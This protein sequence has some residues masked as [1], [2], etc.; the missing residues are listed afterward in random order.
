[1]ARVIHYRLHGLPQHRAG[2]VH[3]QFDG[4]VAERSWRSSPPWLATDYSAGLFEMEY[5]RHLR[6]AE[7][8]DVTAGGFLKLAGDETDALVMALFLRDLSAEYGVRTVLRD[9]GNPLAKLRYLEFRSGRLPSGR[10]LEETLAKRPVIKKVSGH[11][12]MFYPPTYRVHSQSPP[13]P[14]RWGYALFGIR[15]FAPSLL[16][17]EREALKILNGLR[18][19]G[20]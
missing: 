12:I 2:R 4:L 20:R 1:M 17:A 5:L 8:A 7:G 18:H 13:G 16:E 9:D 10:T 6:L 3:E 11:S 15:A 14:E 19:L